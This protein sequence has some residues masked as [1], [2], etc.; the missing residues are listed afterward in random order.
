MKN[1]GIIL[2][3]IY[4]I[5]SGILPF[6]NFGNGLNVIVS[7]LAIS[8]GILLLVDLY[9]RK[10]SSRAGMILLSIWLIATGTVALLG[11]QFPGSE[12]IL[13]VLAI[14]AGVLLL[15]RR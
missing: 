13:S 7:I 2:L 4:L 6:A 14:A 15:L 8:A 3:A 5:A 11:I 12:I 9:G 10:V 1:L